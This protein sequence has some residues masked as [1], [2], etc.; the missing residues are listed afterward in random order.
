MNK[1]IKIKKMQYILQVAHVK[2][3]RSVHYYRMMN[4]RLKNRFEPYYTM[5]HTNVHN[6][7]FYKVMRSYECLKLMDNKT[8]GEYQISL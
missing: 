8:P 4:T 7:N 1:V 2:L 5:I 6:L 3:A